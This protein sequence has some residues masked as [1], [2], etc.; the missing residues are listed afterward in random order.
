M[1]NEEQVECWSRINYIQVNFVVNRN[2]VKNIYYIYY[3]Q[4]CNNYLGLS[5][6]WKSEKSGKRS[7]KLK[8]S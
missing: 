1:N 4:P 6:S 2:I 3:K 8:K 7:E 5:G